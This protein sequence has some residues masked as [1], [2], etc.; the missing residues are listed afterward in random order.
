VLS[1]VLPRHFG[2]RLIGSEAVEM[3][4][5]IFDV[6]GDSWEFTWLTWRPTL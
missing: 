5:L 3:E 1:K 6:N 4:W 2:R